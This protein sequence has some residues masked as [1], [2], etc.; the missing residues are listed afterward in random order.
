MLCIYISMDYGVVYIKVLELI[1]CDL[2]CT[3]CVVVAWFEFKFC[4]LTFQPNSRAFCLI[5]INEFRLLFFMEF[6]VL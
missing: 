5:Y 2:V 3:T 1:W 6:V 4:V